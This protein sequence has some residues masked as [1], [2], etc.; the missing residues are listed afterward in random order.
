MRIN[1]L[2]PSAG[3]VWIRQGYWLFKQNPIT[4]FMLVF[5]YLFVIQFSMLIPVLGLVLVMVCN[6]IISLG[7]LTACKKIIRKEPVRPT[8]YIQ[9]LR[10][11]LPSIRSRLFRLGGI[12]TGLIFLL[13]IFASQF[14]DVE[15]LIPLLTSGNLSSTDLVQEMYTAM[16]IA[17]VLYFPIAMLMWFSPQLIA[18]EGLPINKAMFGSLMAFWLNKGAFFVYFSTWA[19]ILIAVPIF[20]G[21]SFEALGMK[22]YASYLVTPISLT[23][24]TI[25]YCSFYAT[26]KGC[27]ID[28]TPSD[29]PHIDTQA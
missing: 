11:T 8:V 13:S 5:L 18:W 12:Y 27:F 20:L 6:P 28:S 19:I 16:I 14:I 25:L 4:F 21:A 29:T 23:A 24:M 26:W 9:P 10:E 1:Q 15:K 17:A 3:Y 2:P 22:E 7:F